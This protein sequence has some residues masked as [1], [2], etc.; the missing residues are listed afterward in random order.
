MPA[1]G[2]RNRVRKIS[3]NRAPAL[4]TFRS[5][6]EG[7]R[8]M[9]RIRSGA[10]HAL[11]LV[12]VASLL[13][14]C[15]GS[16]PPP[17]TAKALPL[18]RVSLVPMDDQP[19]EQ[20]AWRRFAP[21]LQT[22]QV[23]WIHVCTRADADDMSVLRRLTEAPD[24]TSIVWWMLFAKAGQQRDFDLALTALEGAARRSHDGH[25]R[26]PNGWIG[27]FLSA[28][29]AD[30]VMFLRMV[31]ALELMEWAPLNGLADE[32]WTRYAS[33]LLDTGDIEGAR[34][35][36]GRVR[37]PDEQA[38]LRLD[39]RF[40]GV[41]ADAGEFDERAAFEAAL[42]TD[43]AW[44]QDAPDDADAVLSVQ[45][46]LR[47]LGR[48]E[49]ALALLDTALARPEPMRDERGVDCRNW[50]HNDRA[51]L[52]LELGRPDEANLSMARGAEM[53]EDAGVNISQRINRAELLNRT[54]H[55]QEALAVL[56]FF[57]DSA[58][59]PLSPRGSAL[60][61]A[62]RACAMFRLGR[63]DEA[64]AQAQ[65]LKLDPL[66][67]EGSAYDRVLECA[68]EAG[69]DQKISEKRAPAP[70]RSSSRM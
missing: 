52:L 59:L 58:D 66:G 54:G 43:H 3:E 53:D 70:S 19:C 17:D 50:L 47:A 21:K 49:E 28:L 67:P 55:P 29:G 31:H 36:L 42:V 27:A 1:D 23:P 32:T 8:T 22:G 38:R 48:L 10:M 5:G 62:E 12:A 68:D 24:S 40:A 2:T 57:S 69:S 25:S 41:F 34:K 45:K 60:I 6:L 30:E 15:A 7:L 33:S 20:G 39:P 35:A 26:V 13:A 37:R 65:T 51:Y 56:A 63:L 18:P 16:S 46:D 14:G 9:E 44:L 64:A 4:Y 11:R 61:V